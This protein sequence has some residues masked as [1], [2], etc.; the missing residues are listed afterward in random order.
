MK[1]TSKMTLGEA[2]AYFRKKHK[3]FNSQIKLEKE[4]GISKYS[5]Q[6][7]EQN[8]RYPTK[9]EFKKLCEVLGC[10]EI[11]ERGFSEIEYAQKH[12]RITLCFNTAIC[13]KC[14]KEMYIVYGTRNNIPLSPDCFNETMCKVS[15]EKG[16][17]LEERT[18]KYD[19]TYLANIC[20][21]CG[22]LFGNGY[23]HGFWGGAS[24]TVEINDYTDLIW[25]EDEEVYI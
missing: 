8:R 12:P 3:I 11:E 7:I 17:I 23:L 13:W 20:K 24:E 21:N 10:H 4:T 22:A 18:T 15:R 1:D 2:L 25:E 14:G 19:D 6:Q 5:I 9:K 16:V